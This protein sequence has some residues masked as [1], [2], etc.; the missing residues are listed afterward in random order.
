M[1]YSTIDLFAGG[2]GLSLGLEQAGF[3][4]ILLNDSDP[5]SINTLRKNRPNWEVVFQDIRNL[6]LTDYKYHVDLITGRFPYQSFSYQGQRIT[7]NDTRDTLFYEY[8][9]ILTEVE[10]KLFLVENVRGLLS[11]DNGRTLQSIIHI[12]EDLGYFVFEPKILNA[13]EY[14]VPQNRERLFLIGVRKD[15]YKGDSFPWP[16]PYGAGKTLRDAFFKGDLYNTDVKKSPGQR[17]S[18]KKKAVMKKVPEGGNWRNLPLR[19][20]KKYMLSTFYAKGGRTG[21]ARRLSYDKPSP[22]ILCSPS[23]KQTE[24]CHPTEHRPIS[25]RES[26][27]IQTFPD[28]W[29]FYGPIASQYKQIGNAVPVNL[30]YSIG[31]SLRDYLDIISS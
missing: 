19:I 23:Q 12:F 10:P 3:K 26:A 30:A 28:D 6:S 7:L 16:L 31:V 5:H 21:I 14:N 24:R 8:C 4:H 11:H 2:G 27:R 25:I 20:Q 17:Y 13:N 18:K 15:L 22:T 9:R 29:E 1:I